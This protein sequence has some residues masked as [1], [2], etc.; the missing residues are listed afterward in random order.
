MKIKFLLLLSVLSGMLLLASWPVNGFTPLIFVALVP[1]L[2]IQQHLGDTNKKGMFWYAWLA[3]LLWNVLTTWWIWNSTETGSIM[4]FILN[5]LFMAIVFQ[6]YHLSKQKLFNNQRGTFILLFYWVTWEFLHMNWDLS[7]SWLNLGNV[8]ASK[9]TWIQ[10]YEYTG[11][12]GGTVWIIIGNILVYK[13]ISGIINKAKNS[14]IIF[15]AVELILVI[16]IPLIFSF[17]I[18]NNYQEEDNPVNVVV[19]QP[20]IDPYN[21]Q[22]SLPYEK[23]LDKNL[24]LASRLITD[25]TDFLVFPES[26]LQEDIWEEWI[27]RSISLRKIKRAL[28]MFPNTAIVIGATTYKLVKEGEK[29]TNAAR[30]FTKTLDYYYAFNTAILIENEQDFQLHHKSKLTPGVEIMP[31]WWILKSVEKLAIDLGGTTGTL[32]REDQP[33]AFI[34]K[35]AKVGV[36]PI[37][38]YESVYGEF[39]ANSVKLG[40]G[41]IFVITNDGWWGN[42]PGYKQHFLFSVLRAIETRRSVARSAN[43]GISAFINQRGDV[44]QQTPYW[45]PAVIKQTLNANYKQTYYTKNGDY[46]ARTST[47]VSAL[48]ILIAFTQ[49]YLRKKRSAA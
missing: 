44:L 19:V 26:A 22:Y 23:I 37:I 38:C 41:L 1:L 6:L 24:E 14:K 48:L 30:K 36:S 11:T 49:G 16:L 46:I 9:H 15:S 12:L 8:F 18:Y 33:V 13:I 40:A 21:E 42:T 29:K 3:F 43:T 5:S 32:G 35:E 10:W 45:E 20:N 4:A 25:S 28:P 47:F 17:S 7:W 39:V 27:D 31:S 2:F 34:R